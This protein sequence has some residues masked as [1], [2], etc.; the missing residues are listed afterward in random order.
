MTGVGNAVEK[1]T[2]YLRGH[3]RSDVQRIFAL[4]V[5]QVLPTAAVRFAVIAASSR[6]TT[7]RM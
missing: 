3:G 7:D 4:S 2:H 6:S 5:V 1:E